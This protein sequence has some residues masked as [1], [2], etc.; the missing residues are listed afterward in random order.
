MK[1]NLLSIRQLQ[2]KG[3][4]IFSQH[5]KLKIYHHEHSLIIETVMSSNRMFV[6]LVAST[7][8][9]TITKDST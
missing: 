1:N 7:C 2:E 9:N 5:G 4:S 3:L 6:L 8:F